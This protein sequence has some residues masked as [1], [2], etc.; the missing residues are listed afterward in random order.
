MVME[1]VFCS[2]TLHFAF[3]SNTSCDIVA[4][5]QSNPLAASIQPHLIGF[6]RLSFRPTVRLRTEAVAGPSYEASVCCLS[7]QPVRRGYFMARNFDEQASPVAAN[8]RISV[9]EV[10]KNLV[11]PPFIRP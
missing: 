10:R 5:V 4:A 11:P 7:H 6:H 2:M 3:K 9:P 8:V 1:V